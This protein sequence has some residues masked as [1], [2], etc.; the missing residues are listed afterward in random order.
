MI[1]LQGF[2]PDS[3]PTTAG[4]LTACEA[5]IPYESGMKA[6]PAAVDVGTDALAAACVG[7]TG[8]LDLSGN[9]RLIAGTATKLYELNGS[10]GWTDRSRAG[11]YTLAADNRWSFAQFGNATIAAS[12]ANVLQKSTSGAFANISG[13][14]TAKIVVSAS[15]FV[16]AFNTSSSSD[17]WYCSAYLDETDWTLSVSTQCT[18]G[19]LISSPGAFTAAATFGSDIVAYKM[20]SMFVGRYVGAPEVWKWDR[21]SSEVGCVGQEAV[22][23]T[24][25]GHVFVGVDNIYV[26]D[27]TTPIPLGRGVVRSWLFS[28]LSPAFAYRTIVSWDP[29]NYVVRISY[30]SNSSSDGTPDSCL[31]YHISAQKWGVDDRSIEALV[32]YISPSI[33]YNTGTSIFTGVT[34]NDPANA[35]PFSYDSPFWTAGQAVP[36]VFSTD[37]KIKTLSGTAGDSGFYTGVY[38]DDQGYSMCK[39]VRIRYVQA[40]TSSTCKAYSKLNPNEAIEAVGTVPSRT[41][42]TVRTDGKYDVRVTARWHLYYII[43]TGDWKA[44]AI[45]PE[46]VSA[47]DR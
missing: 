43:N 14:P 10:G 6:A 18:S 20:G 38:G 1:P 30:A 5:V 13:S 29:L 15:D 40:P 8:T 44:T 41:T 3:D 4:V 36:A 21:I 2:S 9:K 19:R 31:V 24:P 26:F 7:A 46:L 17:Q 23:N 45:R 47:G 33:T 22:A 25:I 35:I 42:S 12:P 37:H 27:G 28:R 39:S 34:Y 11:D 32:S 16:V